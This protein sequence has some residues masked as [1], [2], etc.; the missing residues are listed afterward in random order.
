MISAFFISMPQSANHRRIL[1]SILPA[2]IL[3][4]GLELIL[5]LKHYEGTSIAD[6]ESAEGI[7]DNMYLHRRDRI[8]GPWFIP[9]PEY[10]DL[11]RS[12]PWR[13]GRG[14]HNQKISIDS[15]DR[16]RLFALGGST[17]YGTPYEHEKRGFPE[18]TQDRL[19]TGDSNRWEIINMGVAGMDASGFSD[20]LEEVEG[21]DPSGII[22]YTG[23]N[24]IRGALLEA[25]TN[26]YR[27]GI[28]RS[29]ME[30]RSIQLLQDQ[31]RRFQKISI[32]PS[33]LTRQQSDCMQQALQESFSAPPQTHD[34]PLRDDPLYWRAQERFLAGLERSIQQIEAMD[35]P[36]FLVIP[37]IHLLSSPEGALPNPRLNTAQKK[38][39]ETAFQ[40][41][42]KS[43]K[44]EDWQAAYGIDP[45]HALVN[46]QI[47]LQLINRSEILTARRHLEA[48]VERDY[49]SKKITP[50]FQKTLKSLCEN[51][52]NI[53]CVDMAAVFE[54]HS[55]HGIAGS[56][57]FVDFCH[58]NR[59]QGI[60]LIAE[61]LSQAIL[62][63]PISAKP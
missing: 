60:P 61:H 5:R 13:V 35:I 11:K 8:L 54:S 58:P 30:L 40:T 3:F 52:K 17:T 48:A 14:F 43:D 12:N 16:I 33:T 18:A 1:F 9:D 42:Q 36:L 56:E 29:L 21:L 38:Q 27:E 50:T 10:P 20:I 49:R 45:T 41:A 22:I 37:A 24:E 4:G 46:Y 7:P 2:L 47:G 23:N 53:Y 26:P 59:A 44:L 25:C 55:P 28:Q 31:Y 34:F 57:V 19:N 39:F 51:R 6:L 63:S 32:Q 15:G 62:Q